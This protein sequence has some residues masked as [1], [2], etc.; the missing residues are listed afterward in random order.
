MFKCDRDILS[1]LIG[2]YLG[3]RRIPKVSDTIYKDFYQMTP[4]QVI[5]PDGTLEDRLIQIVENGITTLN[6]VEGFKRVIASPDYPFLLTK[7]ILY[8]VIRQQKIFIQSSERLRMF[9]MERAV[10]SENQYNGSFS[11]VDDLMDHLNS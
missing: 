9:V 11:N 7:W 10:D 5:D 1:W 3:T 2:L 4:S 8:G 6:M